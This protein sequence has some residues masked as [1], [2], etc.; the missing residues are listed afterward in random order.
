M[1]SI[2]NTIPQINNALEGIFKGSKL[3]G[4][5]TL[6]DREGKTQP[7]VNDLPVSFDDSYGMQIY[8]RLGN[9][10][11]AYSD[12][13]GDTTD[14][15]NTYSVAAIVFNNEKITKLKQDDIALIIQS[16]LATL[17]ID[18]VGV[19]PVQII[20]NSQ[21]IFATEYKGVPY[22]LNEYQ[23]LMQINYQVAVTYKGNCF[24]LCPEDISNCKN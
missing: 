12:G 8:H 4:I 19:T 18:F 1:Q 6:V 24:N 3:Y 14:T 16:V 22:S 7:V 10:T 11:I 9:V 17:S 15:T 5:A 2:R 23:S 20:L 21:Q 13:Y